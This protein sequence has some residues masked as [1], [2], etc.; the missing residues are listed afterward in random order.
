MTILNISKTVSYHSILNEHSDVFC[1]HADESGCIKD[2]SPI[3]QYKLS[4]QQE[5]EFE[6]I[7]GT[8]LK[9]E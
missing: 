5:V 9:K 8:M 4:H 2:Y 7:V 3:K 1:Q 6:N